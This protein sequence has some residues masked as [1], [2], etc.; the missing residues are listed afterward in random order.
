MAIRSEPA[1][2][3]RCSVSPARCITGSCTEAL[4]EC[5]TREKAAQESRRQ[6]QHERQ[7][8]IQP[9]AQAEEMCV[10]PSAPDSDLPSQRQIR[11]HMERIAG[12]PPRREQ[13]K[14]GPRG[15]I[16]GDNKFRWDRAVWYENFTGRSIAE[17]SLQEQNEL[18]DVIARRFREYTD[19]RAKV[20]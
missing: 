15:D 1:G 19:S 7:P 8:P 18:C 17:V 14:Y 16:A 2:P 13:V 10:Q 4:C 11:L 3:A 5:H 6:E 12:P 9:S 20:Q